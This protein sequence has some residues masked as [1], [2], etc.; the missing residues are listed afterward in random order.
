MECLS[1]I[2]KRVKPMLYPKFRFRNLR[3]MSFSK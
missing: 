3:Y 1:A 2:E